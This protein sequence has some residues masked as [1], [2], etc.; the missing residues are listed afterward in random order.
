ML[1]SGR[2][3]AWFL[4]VSLEFFSDIILLVVLWPWGQL[5]LWQKW[6]PGVFSGG[7]GGQCIRL[8]TLP[9]SC[10][11]VMTSG[12]LNFLEPSGP[13]QACNGTALPFTFNTASVSRRITENLQ[14][15]SNTKKRIYLWYRRIWSLIGFPD[16]RCLRSSISGST[17]LI[18]TSK[19][20]LRYKVHI[21]AKTRLH[22]STG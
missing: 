9:P 22:S 6:V 19:Y 5:S 17:L 12:N 16:N 3:S 2:S 11:V 13:P 10:A 18:W 1:Q 14:I 15:Y 20:M 21:H 4:T 8:T 7:K